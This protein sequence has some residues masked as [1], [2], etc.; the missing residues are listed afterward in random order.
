TVDAVKKFL[1]TTL[2]NHGFSYS[3]AYSF[4]HYYG[5]SGGLCTLGNT[6][7]FDNVCWR[8]K[9]YSRHSTDVQYF[10]VR[11]GNSGMS[12]TI[13]EMHKMMKN[14]TAEII[15]DTRIKEY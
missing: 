7:D 14:L 5:D 15:E 2:L 9:S 12:A 10:D 13:A 8:F 11:I 6:D 1:E 3:D 4:K